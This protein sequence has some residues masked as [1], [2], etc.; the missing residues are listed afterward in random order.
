[1]TLNDPAYVEA[2]RVMAQR[3]LADPSVAE[4]T[5]LDTAFRLATAHSPTP[6]ERRI[7]LGR[8]AK[9]RTQFAADPAGARELSSLGEAPAQ[10]PS[11]L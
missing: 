2:A 6:A 9:L 10:P 8:L 1:V 5:R 3:L 11:I 7:L 4:A